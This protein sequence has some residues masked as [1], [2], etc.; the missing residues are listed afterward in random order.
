MTTAWVTMSIKVYETAD[1]SITD[2][3]HPRRVHL[4]KKTRD[5]TTECSPS[6]IAGGLAQGRKGQV[7]FLAI[8]KLMDDPNDRY[9]PYRYNPDGTC[10][11]IGHFSIMDRRHH[12]ALFT[13]DST[14]VPKEV[15]AAAEKDLTM[16]NLDAT[17]LTHKAIKEQYDGTEMALLARTPHDEAIHGAMIHVPETRPR[18]ESKEKFP[19]YGP[20]SGEMI[21]RFGGPK[22]PG[23]S[24]VELGMWVYTRRIGGRSRDARTNEMLDKRSIGPYPPQTFSYVK[25]SKKD[26]SDADGDAD[27]AS[28]PNPL[29]LVGSVVEVRDG[30]W[31][32]DGSTTVMIHSLYESMENFLSRDM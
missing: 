24:R 1:G 6:V 17:C 4:H 30:D 28:N 31:S 16:T 29:I 21:A 26:D 18:D 27:T 14:V 12:W 20:S 13:I 5:G 32:P 22:Y 23:R 3:Q 7:Y 25:P 9:R 15:V 8:D 11:C 2:W 10:A 19:S